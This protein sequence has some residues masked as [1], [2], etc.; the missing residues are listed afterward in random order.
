MNEKISGYNFC[1]SCGVSLLN[2]TNFCSKCG[3]RILQ[4]EKPVNEFNNLK[5]HSEPKL[6]RK[7]SEYE[8]I[9][10]IL[11]IVLGVIQVATV[12]GI[13]AGA[14]N[15]YAGYT[16]IK[17]SPKILTA[18]PEIPELYEDMTQL[19]IIA[20][21]NLIFGGVIGIVIVVFDYIIRDQVLENRHLFVRK[22]DVQNS[23]STITNQDINSPAST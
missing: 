22:S 11:W 19:I 17:I 15:I 6:L 3:A 1:H 13:I 18:D 7:I 9:S 16:K 10:G 4:T 12:I 14:W 21:I 2:T 23:P 20:I 5:I 8:K